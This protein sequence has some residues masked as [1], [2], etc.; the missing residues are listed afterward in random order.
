METLIKTKVWDLP[1][2]K[3]KKIKWYSDV[4][5]AAKRTLYL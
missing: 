5:I 4:M 2:L 1:P 3:E